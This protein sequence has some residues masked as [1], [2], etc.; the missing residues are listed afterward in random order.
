MKEQL[1]YFSF[2]LVFIFCNLWGE[3]IY[4]ISVC[5]TSTL[6]G[7]NNCK[8]GILKTSHSEVFILPNENNK[9]YSTYLGKFSSYIDAKN[10]LLNASYFIKQQ[11]PFVKQINYSS[12]IS[13]SKPSQPIE[14]NITQNSKEDIEF[15]KYLEEM[16]NLNYLT[17]TDGT[18]YKLKINDFENLIIYIDSS[19]NIMELKGKDVE[20]KIH[21]LKKYSVSTAKST[22]LKPLGEGSITSIS[23]NPEWH[24][25][26][27]TIKAFKQKGI[28]LPTVVPFGNKFNYMGAAKINLTH[29]V[30]GQEIYRIHGTINENTIGTYESSGCIRMKNI[31]VFELAILLTQYSN[32][33]KLS[34]VRV[35]LI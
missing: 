35:I 4:S 11:K 10:A 17:F 22:I 21:Y 9:G 14:Q 23:L 13:N 2:L 28:N 32:L 34:S 33:K 25:T 7:A 1:K 3:E 27:K 20:G 6:D 15:T 30:N 19:K 12:N 5:T 24:P 26:M 18:S 31:D 29:R 16:K 8:L